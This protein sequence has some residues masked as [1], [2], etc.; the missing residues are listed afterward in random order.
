MREAEMANQAYLGGEQSIRETIDGIA[1]AGHC[2]AGA[3]IGLSCV[4]AAA[5]GQATANGSLMEGVTGDAADAA[6]DLQTQLAAIR[7]RLLV[8]VDQDAVAIG[9]F[10]RLRVAGQALRG[11]E[12]L[13]D[14]PREMAELAIRAATLMQSYRRFVHERTRDDLEF[15]INLM[16]GAARSAMLL[17]DSNLRIWPLPELLARYDDVVTAL[18]AQIESLSPLRRIRAQ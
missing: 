9:E 14:G 16:A 10:V 2:Q 5:L 7:E 12:L 6:R 17:L 8:L 18:A 1:Q 3:A 13:C 4:L 11:Y 15:A